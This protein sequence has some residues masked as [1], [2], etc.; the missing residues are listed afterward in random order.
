MRAL[1][2]ASSLPTRYLSNRRVSAV[3]KVMSSELGVG[4]LTL[5]HSYPGAL[6]LTPQKAMIGVCI[7]AGRGG[8]SAGGK[9]DSYNVHFLRDGHAFFFFF[10]SVVHFLAIAVKISRVLCGFSR[11]LC[12][13]SQL[14]CVFSRL[15]CIFFRECFPFFAIAKR[16]SRLLSLLMHNNCYAFFAIVKPFFTIVMY[17]FAIVMHFFAIV[18]HYCYAPFRD[19]YFIFFSR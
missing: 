12:I 3:A 1:I 17:F 13:F 4:G 10:A 2:T 15:L 5:T 19:F 11:L 14:L 8:G 18:M 9:G 6:T 7:L 16:Y